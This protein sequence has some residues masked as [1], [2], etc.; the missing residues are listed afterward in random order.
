MLRKPLL[1]FLFALF[2]LIGAFLFRRMIYQIVILPLAYVWWWL[3]LY[4]RLLP[5]AAIWIVLIFIIL[6]TTMRGL[7]LEIPWGW[8]KPMKRKK[9]Q[10]PIESLSTLIQKSRE[11][12]YYKWSIAN[13]LGRAA[14]E[15]LDQR[16]GRPLKQ[17]LVRFK[18][19][20]WNAPQEVSAYLEAGVNGTFADY[21]RKSWSR[22][23]RTP[24]DVDPQQ[25]IEYLESE[26]EN[27]NGHR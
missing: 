24:L 9:S 20:S 12:N 11:G 19:R 4:Y 14:R 7:L 22:S 18:D 8:S 6:F 21:P 15:L 16:E 2:C 3:T 27:R 1:I 5:Q 17:K 26:L 23:S 25:V 10:G 13:R